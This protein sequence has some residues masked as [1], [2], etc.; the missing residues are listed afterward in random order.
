VNYKKEGIKMSKL[1]QQALR[2]EILTA[3]R[4]LPEL[5]EQH[6]RSSDHY[7]A[8]LKRVVQ[9]WSLMKMT[10]RRE[11]FLAEVN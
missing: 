11:E 10:R 4:I 1:H 6:G 7:Q 9:L 8:S 3:A 5:R 2:S